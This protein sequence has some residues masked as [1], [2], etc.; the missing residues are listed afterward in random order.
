MASKMIKG[1]SNT[2]KFEFWHVKKK[3]KVSIVV[4]IGSLILFVISA[5]EMIFYLRINWTMMTISIVG[6][7]GVAVWEDISKASNYFVGV[8]EKIILGG[9]LEFDEN[10]KDETGRTIREFLEEANKRAMQVS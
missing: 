1:T 7:I 4:V 10:D 6:I 2:E 3:N 9:F 5:F 8:E